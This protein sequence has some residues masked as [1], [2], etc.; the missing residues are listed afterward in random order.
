MHARGRDRDH[1]LRKVLPADLIKSVFGQNRRR[2]QRRSCCRL[3]LKVMPKILDRG[4]KIRNGIDR[5][6]WRECSF[7]SVLG[8]I[9][10]S[11]KIRKDARDA[12]RDGECPEKRFHAAGEGKLAHPQGVFKEGGRDLPVAGEDGESDRKVET[13]ALGKSRLPTGIQRPNVDCNAGGRE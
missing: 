3:Q 9:V 10:K 7:G 6:G 8:G 4:E 5:D 13:S 11:G 1:S 2:S 12:F